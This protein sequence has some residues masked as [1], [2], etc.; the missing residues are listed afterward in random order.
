ML[1][2]ALTYDKAK[3][4]CGPRSC[5]VRDCIYWHYQVGHVLEAPRLLAVAVHRQG[6]LPQR[7]QSIWNGTCISVAS[8]YGCVSRPAAAD[9]VRGRTPGMTTHLRDEVADDPAVVDAHAR[10]VRVEDP[11]DPHLHARTHERVSGSIKLDEKCMQLP[12]D[13]QRMDAWRRTPQYRSQDDD[14]PRGWLRGGSPW[15]ASPP[16][17]CPRRSSS[18]HLH[19]NIIH[20]SIVGRACSDD[21]RVERTKRDRMYM[22]HRLA[23]IVVLYTYRWG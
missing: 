21:E 4:I 11:G 22:I 9:G 5:G 8:S 3:L 6:I 2:H 16:C 17:A 1:H 15:S 19:A 13:P 7:L 12:S 14:Q 10:P 18:G 20:R 23:S